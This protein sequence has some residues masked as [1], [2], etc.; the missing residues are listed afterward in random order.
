MMAKQYTDRLQRPEW[1]KWYGLARWQRL[2]AIQLRMHPLCAM[3]AESDFV[4]PA[5]VVDHIMPPRGSE[6]LFWDS[7]N[8]QSLCL[9]H[10]NSS[11]QQIEKGDKGYVRDIGA[12]GWAVDVNHP[13]NVAERRM[14]KYQKK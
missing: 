10:H 14:Q 5:T 6:Q 3:C 7:K 2:R 13:V 11:K 9:S 8:L 1:H 4:I 12:D